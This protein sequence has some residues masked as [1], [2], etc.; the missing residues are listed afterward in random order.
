MLIV[1]LKTLHRRFMPINRRSRAIS[2]VQLTEIIRICC[3]Y[4][5]RTIRALDIVLRWRGCVNADRF[6]KMDSISL[7][8]RTYDPLCYSLLFPSGK[9]G[10]RS[11][12]KHLDLKG[13]RQNVLSMKFYSQLL[14][15]RE[16][17][18]NIL[19]HSG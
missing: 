1:F 11:K 17:D 5:W 4:C 10:W 2:G 9:Y 18:F 13:K 19:I 15:Q 6:E 14:F 3:S 7:G 8:N 16:C 12:L